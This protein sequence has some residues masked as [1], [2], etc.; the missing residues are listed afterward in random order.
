MYPDR[1]TADSINALN[2]EIAS[3]KTARDSVK[4][5]EELEALTTRLLTAISNLVQAKFNVVFVTVDL[6]STTENG[7]F[8]DYI[9]YGKPMMPMLGK[10][11]EVVVTTDNGNTSTVIDNFDQKAS[12]VITKDAK[13]YAYLQAKTVQ[14]VHQRLLSSADTI[15]LLQSDMLPKI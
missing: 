5:N 4:N 14:R 6:D 7:K 9:E 15:R 1:Y 10:C 2:V 11:K 12:F 13:I 3:V 8:N